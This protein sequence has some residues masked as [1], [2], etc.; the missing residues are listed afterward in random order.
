MRK[1]LA[2]SLA[3]VTL[4]GISLPAM[5]EEE[6]LD[7]NTL[8]NPT[9]TTASKRAQSA[10]EAPAT[11]YVISEDDIKSRGYID[12]MDALDDL[13]GVFLSKLVLPEVGSN[14]AYVRGI[15]GNNKIVFLMNG[16]RIH[17]APKT[18]DMMIAQDFP[19]V[20]V[21]R[22][23]V[24]V[25]PASALY[26]ADAMSAVVNV[27]TK[28]GAE[29]E[30]LRVG[31]SYGLVNTTSD[32]L[33]YGAKLSEDASVEIFGRY[34][35]TDY[36]DL[37]KDPQYKLNNGQS[38]QSNWP[39]PNEKLINPT[40]SNT[41][42]VTYKHK[43][44]SIDL[45]R[46]Q[47]LQNAAPAGRD[48]R[49]VINPKTG[50]WKD[51]MT[52]MNMGYDADFGGLLSTTQFTYENFSLD[53]SSNFHWNSSLEADA[54]GAPT[55]DPT[56]VAGLVNPALDANNN[57]TADRLEFWHGYKYGQGRAARLEQTFNK[58]I[59]DSINLVGGLTAEDFDA[60]PQT[61][62][63]YNQPMNPNKS[64]ND[65]GGVI[66]PRVGIHYLQYQN[67]GVYLQG[68]ATLLSNLKTTVGG[69]YDYNTR[70]EP[71][72]NPR[73]GVVY[74]PTDSTTVKV[75]YGS[76]FLAPTTQQAYLTWGNPVNN[77]YMHLPNPNL[78]PQK[79]T[80]IEASISQAFGKNL[81][82]TGTVFQNTLSDLIVITH[83]NDQ[84]TVL[85]ANVFY[86][87]FS[88]AASASS[89]GAELRVDALTMGQRSWLS[90]AY[91]DTKQ[92]VGG[93]AT[94]IPDAVPLMLKGGIDI[95]PMANFSITPRFVWTSGRNVTETRTWAGLE[96]GKNLP[97]ALS[98]D[99]GS[100]YNLN[101]N[102]DIFLTASNLLDQQYY[103]FNG[104]E[105]HSAIDKI[106]QPGRRVLLGVDYRF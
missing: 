2:S 94:V 56:K 25:G 8:L 27:I 99:L 9:V 13:P 106:P 63:L 14:R 32:Y 88:N 66:D 65:Q 15:P 97:G 101:D 1:Y 100:R 28:S 24:A 19:L 81:S 18:G 41:Q 60:V 48:W 96:A 80:T 93:V 92:T 46:T 40:T 34:F 52:S 78:K 35:N 17:I 67:Y 33:S 11:V 20:N 68:E 61:T 42:V 71:T 85:G 55:N 36:D 59:T 73:A 44:L 39:N 43:G 54:T 62:D 91:A 16:R 104:E 77:G 26:G 31:A 69:R 6:A 10:K 95:K 29:L 21:K 4:C 23:E 72:F 76:A 22:I 38:Y 83:H 102:A 64:I 12:L 51:T 3:L 70:Y 53:P 30:G 49:Y 58:D 84:K 103:A 7:L 87:D 37:T 50:G 98:I 47:K 75:L 86:E 82:V 74:S 79:G 5:A 105:A 90:A 57:G 45:L 89:K